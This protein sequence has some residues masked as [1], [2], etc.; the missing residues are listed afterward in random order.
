M[1]LTG[2]SAVV[3]NTIAG[4][5]V[6]ILK[7]KTD[8]SQNWTQW[9]LN[10]HSLPLY[11]RKI[12]KRITASMHALLLAIDH[13]INLFN[14][15]MNNPIFQQCNIINSLWLQ[16]HHE[17]INTCT[18]ESVWYS[19]G[20]TGR[21]RSLLENSLTL[22]PPSF[23]PASGVHQP[24]AA[25]FYPQ[26]LDRQTHYDHKFIFTYYSFCWSV[27]HHVSKS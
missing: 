2:K 7:S 22:W 17:V 12:I 27:I 10:L 6:Y 20:W 19:V 26:G 3:N 25:H 24:P 23:P 13:L 5:I 14:V 11:K 18:Y 16:T 9:S 15:H 4:R 21:S 1:T 8:F